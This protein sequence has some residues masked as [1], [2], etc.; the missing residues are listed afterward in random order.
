MPAT[1]LEKPTLAWFAEWLPHLGMV[2]LRCKWALDDKEDPKIHL[3]LQANQQTG[4]IRLDKDPDNP[5]T[6]SLPVPAVESCTVAPASTGSFR[7]KTAKQT[8]SGLVEEPKVPFS[9]RD[10]ASLNGI[11][12]K[13]C[14]RLVTDPTTQWQRIRDLPSE[15]WEELVGAWACHDEVYAKEARAQGILAKSGMCFVGQGHIQLCVDD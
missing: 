8:H 10:L 14:T 6:L 12:C 11:Q 9:A 13:Y 5:I 7:Y 1:N 4:Q 2:D 3:V 15:G